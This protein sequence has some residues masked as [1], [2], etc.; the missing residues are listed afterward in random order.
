MQIVKETSGAET[1]YRLVDSSSVGH[2]L[3]QAVVSE[4]PEGIRLHTIHVRAEHRGKG[5]GGT[6]IRTILDEMKPITLCTGFGNTSFFKRHGFEVTEIAESL[7]FMKWAPRLS[8]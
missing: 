4:T 7:V 5:L 1:V 2:A 6:L 3:G 8:V